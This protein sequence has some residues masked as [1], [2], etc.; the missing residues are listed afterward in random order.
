MRQVST[1]VDVKLYTCGYCRPKVIKEKPWKHKWTLPHWQLSKLKSKHCFI[2]SFLFILSCKG[3]LICWALKKVSGA[4][5]VHVVFIAPN[6]LR[7]P[8]RPRHDNTGKPTC[9]VKHVQKFVKCGQGLVFKIPLPC[10]KSY[11]SQA[12]GCPSEKLREHKYSC[13]LVNAPS[14]SAVHCAGSE[15]TP[16]C[17]ERSVL[18]RSQDKK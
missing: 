8:R 6:K 1:S 17:K 16:E 12:D 9:G 18:L 2:N 15:C 11:I 10:G 13:T 14:N 5:N 7:G 4:H 3:P